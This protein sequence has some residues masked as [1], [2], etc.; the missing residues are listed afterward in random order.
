MAIIHPVILSGGSGTR[1]WPLSRTLYP[2]QL[3]ALAAERSMLQE[4]AVRIADPERFAPPMVVCNEAHRFIIAEQ[5]L[6][7]GVVASTIVIEPEGRNTAPAAAAA[8]VILA[9]EAADA[10]VMVLPS[11]HV[12]GDTAGFAAAVETAAKAAAAGALVAFGITPNAPETGYGYIERGAAWPGVD[13]AYRI[14]RFVEKPD[15]ESAEAFVEGGAHAWNSG[16]FVFRADR[17]LA[18]LERHQPAIVTAARAAVEGGREDLDF[19]R[20]EAT[21][22]AASPSDSIDYAVMEKTKDAAVVPADIAWSDVGAWSALWELGGKDAAGNVT[23]GDVLAHDAAGSY[24][25]SEGPMV[26][27]LGVEDLIVVATD[28]AV[29]VAARGR[30]QEVKALT[31]RLAE[32]G[33]SEHESHTLVHR[34][35]GSYQTVDAGERFQVKR[36]V[37]KPGRRLSLQK[38]AKRAEHWVVVSG[39]ARV[40]R[41][42][43]TFDLEPNQST[44]IP[45]GT[46][47]RLENPGTE[48]LHLIEVQSG[49]YLGEDDIVRLDD[50]YGRE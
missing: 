29:L 13:G 4:T 28:D 7:A 15:R 33:R 20:L 12:I 1:L 45:V 14:A 16:M 17:Y 39:T 43:E 31:E 26:A 36:I 10:I 49:D 38:H 5:L 19:F 25:R 11:D 40:T 30:V 23:V 44:Y 24:L 42:K 34:P 9:R 47:H 22:F 8:A 3:L 27:A 37:V 46:V 50:E 6:E 32:A 41:D 48:P 21:S 18:E 35:W 2:K